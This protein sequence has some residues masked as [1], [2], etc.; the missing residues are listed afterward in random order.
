MGLHLPYFVTT[1]ASTAVPY[2]VDKNHLRA[3][4]DV[5]VCSCVAKQNDSDFAAQPILKQF[6]SH[7]IMKG[8]IEGFVAHAMF[9]VLAKGYLSA[10]F[11][12]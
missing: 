6:L 4:S 11:A 7:R 3:Q 10:D 5:P 1:W 12:E 8:W 2:S 9:F